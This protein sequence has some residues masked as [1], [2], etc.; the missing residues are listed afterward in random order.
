MCS[1]RGPGPSTRAPEGTRRTARRRTRPAQ[2]PPYGAGLRTLRSTLALASP[3][4]G[5]DTLVSRPK[6]SDRRLA[7]QLRSASLSTC[8][9]VPAGSGR[10]DLAH[11]AT[12]PAGDLG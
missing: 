10:L 3:R 8:R 12:L 2:L 9:L 4:Q 6:Q 5:G 11:L 1:R 7:R